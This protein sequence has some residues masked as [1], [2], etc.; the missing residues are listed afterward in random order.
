[1]PPSSSILRKLKLETVAGAPSWRFGNDR[2]DACITQRGGHLAP[3]TFRTTAGEIQ[4]FSVAPWATETLAPDTPDLLKTLRGDFFCAPFGGNGTPWRGE[5]HPPHGETASADWQTPR[6]SSPSLGRLRFEADL[7]TTVRAG[8]VSKFI[9]LRDGETNLY[10]RH[11]LSGLTG[12]MSLGHHAMLKCP[13]GR[14]P[15]NI[16][17]SPFKAGRVLPDPFE[18]PAVGGYSALKPGATFSDLS[19]V[20]LD[21]GTPTDLSRFPAREGFDDLVMVTA[22]PR[23][24]PA[25]ST[26]AFP[27]AGYLWF[28]LRDPAVLA[29]TILWF[30]HGGRHY[31]PWNGRHRGVIGIEDVTSHFHYGLAES[32]QNHES[33]PSIIPTIHRLNRRKPTVVNYI[34]G[35]VPI[36]SNFDRVKNIRFESVGIQFQAHSGVKISHLVDHK[37]IVGSA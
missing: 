7:D 22:K 10:L 31:A 11:T 12:P 35:I 16:G 27:D 26:L 20:P 36:P 24:S 1:V 13:E 8:H 5:S 37:F 23:A 4:P 17:L 30:S 14:E 3:V 34:M 25:W 9:E 6:L 33:G 32:A 18:N 2:V 15:G 29:S 28:S 19:K 21:N